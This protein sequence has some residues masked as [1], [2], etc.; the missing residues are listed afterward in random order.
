MRSR[1]CEG[2]VEYA[3]RP[4]VES[5]KVLKLDAV[6]M[7]IKEVTSGNRKL[8]FAHDDE[9][10]TIELAQSLAMDQTGKVSIAYAISDPPKGM[11]FILPSTS[12]PKRPIMVYTMSEPIE[13]RY[14]VPCHDWPNERWTTDILV[15]VPPK[16]SAVAN[17]V[18]VEKKPSEKST[19]F[20]WRNEVP[21]DPH[22]M[23]LA[24]GE[25]V[26]LSNTWEGRSI[27]VFTQPGSEA[28][29]R[30]TFERVPKML[31]F[32]TELIGVEFPY[33]V[34]HHVTVV[35]HHHGGM[36]HAG[37]SFA[38]PG[39]LSEGEDG[40]W[41][42]EHAESW[43]I[44]HM[45]AHQWFGGMVNYRSVS[46]AW[47]NEGFGTY[48][49]T[50]WTAQTDA[51]DR[52]AW[53]LH[54]Y[55]E[56]IAQTDSS[57]TGSPMVRRDLPEI[58][59][60]YT[61]EGGKVYIKGAWVLHMLRQQLGEKVFWKAVKQYLLDHQGQSVETA[62]L[63]HAFEVASGR[64]LEQFFQQ[65]VFGRGIPHFE[66]D[67]S[68]NLERREASVVIRQTQKTDANTPAFVVPLDLF[69]QVDGKVQTNRVTAREA[70]QEFTFPFPSQP[71]LFC[72]DPAGAVLK[73][74]KVKAPQSLIIEQVRNGP[75]AL[76]RWLAVDA[77]R[78]EA[79]S[80]V[81]KAFEGALFDEKAYWAVRASAAEALGEAQ[82]EDALAVLLR[83]ERE[84]KTPQRIVA[85]VL[86]GLGNYTVSRE[87]HE[88][89]LRHAGT[90][91]GLYVQ[92]AAIT[93][94]GR[95]RGSTEL[96]ERSRDALIK[97]AQKDSR[98]YVRRATFGAL[99]SFEDAA[100]YD[101]ILALSKPGLDDELRPDAVRLLGRLGRDE[102]HR[103]ATRKLL[104]GWLSESD[105]SV[106][107]AAARA[108]GELKD[109]RAIADL[110]RVQSSAQPE[111]IRSAAQDAIAAIR[112]PDDPKQSVSGL[113]DR[114]A[115]L[116]KQNQ[117]LEKKVKELTEKVDA[118]SKPAGRKTT[119]EKSR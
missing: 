117:Q 10:L 57:E 115:T 98:R 71:K 5:L 18:L 31:D 82:S 50:L 112:R 116:E 119:K 28:A 96:T 83:A 46:Q 81:T 32:Y 27:S 58:E 100:V 45:M 33:P 22:L 73:K 3:F 101:A 108:L 68:W 102:K 74:L 4:R 6:G 53:N 16:F 66:V 104:T 23:G 36:E 21:T 25:L 13:A 11:H 12:V 78:Q 1:T 48:L 118:S 54:R 40:D 65:W 62:D 89:V 47:L 7:R 106:Q 20:H 64:D 2:R 8:N 80:E 30:F 94:L 56:R 84:L 26:E 17:G 86:E 59:D 38:T 34:Y 103:D 63:R 90:E 9:I 75:T 52:V 107:A 85:A 79:V 55:A 19:T 61:F 39:V 113:L 24:V 41:P 88:A 44:A 95:L 43:L 29:A 37:F 93:A 51:P 72:V 87:A 77:L 91:Q 110:E 92:Y 76:S 105:H 99:R 67:Y 114:L 109:P 14:W 49:D 111:E 97:A 70:R 35:N 42:R 15:T 69:F 60:I